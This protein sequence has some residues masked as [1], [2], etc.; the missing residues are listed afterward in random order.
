MAKIRVFYFRGYDADSHLVVRSKR[1]ATLGAI[2]KVG[3]DPIMDSGIDV[4]TDQLD[5]EGFYSVPQGVPG[6]I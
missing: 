3:G 1:P 6:P 5:G 4:N 2:N